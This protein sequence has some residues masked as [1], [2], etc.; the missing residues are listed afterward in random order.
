[1][2]FTGDTTYWY[3]SGPVQDLTVEDCAFVNQAGPYFSVFG[4]VEFTKE[5]PFYHKNIT[6]KNCSFD[7]GGVVAELNHLNGFTFTGNISPD[8]MQIVS[9]HSRNIRTDCSTVIERDWFYLGIQFQAKGSRYTKKDIF[10]VFAYEFEFINI[11]E[12]NIFLTENMK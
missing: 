9:A 2:L 4:E 12:W 10:A 6:V 5:F 7:H 8:T 3:E 1:M 11:L